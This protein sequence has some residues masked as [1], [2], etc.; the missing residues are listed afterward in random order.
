MEKIIAMIMSLIMAAGLSAYSEGY[1]RQ[2]SFKEAVNAFVNMSEI[3]KMKYTGE[4]SAEKWDGEAISIDSFASLTKKNGKDFVILNLTDPHFSDY[5][6]RAFL[7]FASSSTAKRLVSEIKP[8]LI[9]VTGDIVCADST[10]YSIKRFTDLMESFGVP[11]APVF[12]NHDDE[13]NCDLN[14][15]CDIML[16]SPNCLLKKGDPEMGYGNYGIRILNEDGSL[17]EVIVMLDSHHDQANEKQQKWVKAITDAAQDAEISLFF[18]VPLPEYQYAYDEAKTDKGWKEEYKAYGEK[19]ENVCCERDAEGKPV[20][21]GFFD[22]IKRAGNIKYVFCGHEHMND[23]SILYQGVRLTYTMKLGKGSGFQ[24]GFDGGTVITIGENGI[25][26]INHKV[27][28]LF[29]FK[30]EEI[31]RIGE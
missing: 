1:I 13:G 11:W 20:Q 2:T 27:K 6:Y 21:R 9:T 14:Y 24:L 23:F 18:H 19:H 30:D 17:N 15:L 7:A 12:G 29:S 5:D 31:I 4:P 26:C 3:K 16:K 28:S 22:I 25:N 10:V 8:D